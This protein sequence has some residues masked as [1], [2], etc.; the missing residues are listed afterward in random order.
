M[1]PVRG[2]PNLTPVPVT[3]NVKPVGKDKNRQQYRS[4]EK[5]HEAA[6]P[7]SAFAEPAP[8]PSSAPGSSPAGSPDLD[9]PEKRGQI[10][11]VK[12]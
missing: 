10:I 8:D 1:S 2:I 7:P 12:A 6:E 9:N 5:E 4:P 3:A 11:D